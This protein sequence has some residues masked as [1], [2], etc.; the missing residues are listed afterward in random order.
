MESVPLDPASYSGTYKL[1]GGRP[2]LDLVNTVSWP[3]TDRAHDWLDLPA[4]AV[5]WAQASGLLSDSEAREITTAH[6]ANVRRATRA[7]HDLRSLRTEVRDVVA[8]LA[9]GTRPTATHVERFNRTLAASVPRHHIDP[10]TLAWTW[11]R[12]RTL[13]DIFGPII[14]DTADLLA[15]SDHGRLGH[16][17]SCDWVFYDYTRNRSKRWCDM[18]DCGSRDKASRYYRRHLSSEPN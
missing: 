16:C 10:T 14:L 1:V 5:V 7:A 4:N 3:R 17:P 12:V 15:V 8:P 11:G 6:Q 9:Q 18:A 2:C 13:E